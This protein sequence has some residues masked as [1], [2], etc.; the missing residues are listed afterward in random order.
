M[1]SAVTPVTGFPPQAAAA[2]LEPQVDPFYQP[3]AGY[4]SQ[5]PGTILRT[6]PISFA[7]LTL[8][9]INVQSWQLLYRT[10]DLFG[11]PQAAVT[12]VVLPAGPQR[13]N[14]P[15]VS[16]NLFYDS[17]NPACGP[18]HLY[19]QGASAITAATGFQGQVELLGIAYELAKGWAVS[20]PDHEGPQGHMTVA[21]E[22]GYVILDGIRASEQFTPLGLN[23]KDT[24]VGLWGYSG[25][26]MATGWAAEVQPTYAPEL[27]IKGMALGAPVPDM[28][29]L[30]PLVGT[31]ESGLVGIGIS[32]LAAAYPKFRDALDSHLTPQGLRVMERIRSRCLV[33][34]VVAELFDNY[35]QYLT[36]PVKEFM[37]LPDVKE[38]FDD[39]TLGRNNP[40]V[41]APL[42]VYQAA[43]DTAVPMES[44]DTMVHNYCAGGAPVQYVRDHLSEHML[45][46]V[47][48]QPSALNWL[49]NRFTEGAPTPVGCT[50]TDQL[51][52]FQD[53]KNILTQFEQYIAAVAGIVGLPLG[54]LPGQK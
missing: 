25:G 43:L 18:S 29:A 35:Q 12:T 50:T 28:R 31:G 54:P 21:R 37:E 51:T 26:G 7:A 1:L 49:D 39:A 13:M 20:I 24:P 40:R 10:T 33:L 5:P 32:S 45:L 42:Y 4:E 27:N 17:A 9:K 19:Q 14:R 48:G 47:W 2:P 22:P 44:T 8:F 6:R 15:L 34:N 23:G 46:A 41:T 30:L 36:I 52:T 3:P 11:K 53:A 38:T 16:H